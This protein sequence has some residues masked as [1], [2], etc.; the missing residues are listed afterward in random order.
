MAVL[1]V[2]VH[3]AA[4]DEDGAVAERV[5]GRVGALGRE[6]LVEAGAAGADRVG[7]E[8]GAASR[9]WTIASTLI[10]PSLPGPPPPTPPK[11]VRP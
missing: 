4:E 1:L 5:R 8:A 2:D 10:R 6:P 11:G 3:R 7:E 9:W